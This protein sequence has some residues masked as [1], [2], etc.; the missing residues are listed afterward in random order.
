VSDEPKVKVIK[1]SELTPDARNANQGT[2]RGA[3]MLDKSLSEVG[4][5]RSIVADKN[6]RVPAGNKTLEAAVEAGFEEAVVIESDGRRL[7]VVQ[8]TD[9]DLED[10]DPNSAARRYA[11]WDNRS[12]ETGLEWEFDQ[13]V[14]DIESGV[15]LS[16]LWFED[17]LADEIEARQKT[18]L[19][20]PGDGP[21]LG[22]AKRQIKA[23]MYADQVVTLERALKA[24]GLKNRGE[25]LMAVCRG[26]LGEDDAT[27]QLD[28][29]IE[30]IVAEAIAGGD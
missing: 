9:W 6:N 17:E 25:A 24:T 13:I 7:V 23:V 29:E 21:N 15:D 11:Y 20:E 18:K 30:S 2:E 16:D 1:L 4:A 12:G 28:A 14:Q 19:G 26:Y 10:G 5:G 27:G 3:Y 22:D 8:R